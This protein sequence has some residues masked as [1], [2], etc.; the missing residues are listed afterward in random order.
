MTVKKLFFFSG[1]KLGKRSVYGVAS[2]HSRWRALAAGPRERG[3]GRRG[4]K[5][6]E[7]RRNRQKK[8]VQQGRT[9]NIKK[10]RRDRKRNSNS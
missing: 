6:E 1:Q 4:R 2:D 8:P 10:E 7:K 9:G 5:E 3:G